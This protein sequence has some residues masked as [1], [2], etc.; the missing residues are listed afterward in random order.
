MKHKERTE[1][2]AASCMNNRNTERMVN[3]GNQMQQRDVERL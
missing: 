1:K 3:K 2:A